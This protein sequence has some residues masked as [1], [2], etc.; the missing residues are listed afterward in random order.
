MEKT[1]VIIKP[2]AMERQLGGEIL[3][4][5]EKNRLTIENIRAV[6]ADDAVLREHY[7]EHVE[8]DFYPDLSAYMKSG[9]IIVAA[10]QGKDA[11]KVV[12]EINGSTN[13]SKAKPNTIR[14][15]YGE[16][17]QR[18]TVHGSAS[19]EEAEREIEIWFGKK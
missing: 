9:K 15:I 13:P 1:L 7:A 8:R 16:N 5:Y 17:V 2:D 10:I 6:M 11:V 12:R 19:V 14:F 3:S 4:I 18:N